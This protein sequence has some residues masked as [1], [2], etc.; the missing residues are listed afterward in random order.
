MAVGTKW[1]HELLD[2][3]GEMHNVFNWLYNPNLHVACRVKFAKQIM[4]T[5]VIGFSMFNIGV[6]TNNHLYL[7]ILNIYIKFN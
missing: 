3:K 6:T 7:F 5:L 4:F 2:M 1:D